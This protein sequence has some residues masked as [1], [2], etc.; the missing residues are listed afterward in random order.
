[1]TRP[2][3]TAKDFDQIATHC[4]RWAEKSLLIAR[5]LIVDG[6]QL[7]DV[8]ARY[9]CSPAYAN[10]IRSRFYDK[11]QSVRVE[12]FKQQVN[13]ETL[14][15]LAA[16]RG[17]IEKLAADGIEV[18]QLVQYLKQHKVNVTADTVRKFLT[19]ATS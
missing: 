13:P 8:A 9:E 4:G 3:I 1:M 15:A 6:A 11:A 16:Y 2:T 17:D 10:V 14:A 18:P 19:G 7:S 5:E 12:S